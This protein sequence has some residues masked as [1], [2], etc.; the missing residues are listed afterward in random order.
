MHRRGK[1]GFAPR[2]P[3]DHQLMPVRIISTT[4]R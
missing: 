3:R 4:R 1:M 2:T